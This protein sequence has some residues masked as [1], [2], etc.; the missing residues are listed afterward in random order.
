M[1]DVGAF[2]Q[3]S[4]GSF[5]I[6]NSVVAGGGCGPNGS[7]GCT[8]GSGNLSLY[9]TVS[10]PGAADLSRQSPYSSRSGFWYTGLGNAPTAA[11][12]NVGGRIVDSN[13]NPVAGASIRLTGT[14]NRLTITD[15]GG[16]YQFD[17]VETNGFYT[18]TPSRANFVLSPSQRSF[19]QLG[20]HTEAA[21]TATATS[22]G[23]NPLDT[24]EYFVRQQYLDFLGREPDESGFN[25]WVNNLER[26]GADSQCRA[27]ARLNVSAAFFISIEFQ[28]S[29]SFIYDLYVVTLGR[30]PVFT[31]YASDRQQVVGGANLDAA[32]TIFAQSFAQRA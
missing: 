30:R 32:K 7:G 9:G 13:G 5:K 8:P 20:Q 4:G 17:N 19:N 15:A 3:S 14:Q 24:T 23:L 22:D 25:F 12:G 29:G 16:N 28:Q 6:A 11:S 1:I 18:V 31:E 10:E 26:C 2:S 27:A 21:F